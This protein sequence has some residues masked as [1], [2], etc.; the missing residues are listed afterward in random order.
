VF[1]AGLVVFS[2]YQTYI[3]GNSGNIDGSQPQNMRKLLQTEDLQATQ[4][5]LQAMEANIGFDKRRRQLGAESSYS[6]NFVGA[7][8][9]PFQFSSPSP[10]VFYILCACAIPA[11]KGISFQTSNFFVSHMPFVCSAFAGLQRIIRL[12]I[13]ERSPSKQPRLFK[14]HAMPA[15][16]PTM[17]LLALP[18]HQ[19]AAK[20]TSSSTTAA[21]S[22]PRRTSTMSL[23]A[24]DGTGIH[25]HQ[26]MK[27]PKT[28][29]QRFI[30]QSV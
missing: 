16:T 14:R 15:V 25:L 6:K 1:F 11:G 17:R 8:P 30:G 23:M 28:R 20:R 26:P 12:G 5:F 24:S 7:P 3:V 18:W 27:I 9:P 2:I 10:S 22:V 13:G 29:D 19:R 21:W 4:T